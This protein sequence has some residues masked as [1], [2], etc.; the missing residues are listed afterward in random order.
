M[1]YWHEK[2]KTEIVVISKDELKELIR[3]VLAE[4][5]VE[6]QSSHNGWMNAMQAAKYLGVSRSFLIKLEKKGKSKI[7]SRCQEGSSGILKCIVMI[8]L[9]S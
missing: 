3:E 2:T 5:N 1:N 7:I 6:S 8:I 9:S 4:L